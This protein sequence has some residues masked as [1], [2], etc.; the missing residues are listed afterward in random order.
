M[1]RNFIKNKID[2]GSFFINK[3]LLINGYI[4]YTISKIWNRIVSGK[5][6]KSST[7]NIN[8]ENHEYVEKY[9][10]EKMILYR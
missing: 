6:T 1:Q 10:F 3:K 2:D 4:T 9:A 5:K 8:P 7:N